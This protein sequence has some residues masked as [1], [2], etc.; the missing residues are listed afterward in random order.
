MGRHLLISPY[1][2][3]LAYQWAASYVRTHERP[4]IDLSQGVPGISPPDSLLEAI[5]KTSSSPT[6]C[7]Y[8]PMNGEPPMRLALVNE[9]NSVY[10][11][12]ADIK[13]QDV[14]LTSGCNMAFIAA[15]MSVGESINTMNDI[16]LDTSDR[17]Y[18]YMEALA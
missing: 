9:M 18:D 8:G 7:G 2:I 15:V 3:P 6:A 1:R 10:G 16:L 13:P 11:E 17:V 4:L 14:A 12:D 5:G